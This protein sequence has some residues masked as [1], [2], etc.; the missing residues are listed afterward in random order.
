MNHIYLDHQATTPVSATVIEAMSRYLVDVPGNPHSSD[1]AA[2]WLAS[3]SLERAR[4]VVAGAIGAESQ[5]L[6]FTSGATEANNIAI[7]GLGGASRARRR[8][9]IS[10]IEHHAVLAPARE[11]ARRGFELVVVPCSSNGI[12]DPD[13]YC[14][15]VDERTLIASLMLVN[16]EI[17]TVQPVEAVAKHCRSAGALFHV[18]AAQ[19]LRW[20][21]MD[22]NALGCTSLSLSS[23]KIGGPMGIGA[24]WLDPDAEPRLA[25]LQHGGEQERGLRPGT[26]PAFLAVGFA[27]AVSELPSISA[28]ADW[29][30]NTEALWTALRDAVPGLA[31]NGVAS[32]RHPGNLNILL[33]ACDSDVLIAALQPT[34]AISQGSAC[35][36]GQPEPSH[37]LRA[38]GLSGLEASRSLRIST[39][40]TTTKVELDLFV[41]A[42]RAAVSRIVTE[43]QSER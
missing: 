11:L 7:L 39:S 15:Q 21:P 10:A 8:I 30:T 42:F 40:T 4:E 26:L 12:V 37:V 3:D 5:D 33:P 14:R 17:G 29:R 38:L 35:T 24:L 16:N 36:S 6:I 22:V 34:F 18:D 32:P 19:A 13:E 20:L 43:H 1:H 2:G 9:V 31:L 23:H 27:K 28:V 25:P 41:E